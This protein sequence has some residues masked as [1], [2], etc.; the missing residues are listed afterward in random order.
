[1]ADII[2]VVTSDAGPP[3][4]HYQQAVIHAGVV[5]ASG[6]LG[7][8]EMAAGSQRDIQAQAAY[9]LDQLRIVLRAAGSDLDRSLKLTIYV[10]DVAFW[11]TVNQVFAQHFGSHKPA[12]SVVTCA[13]LRLNSLIE[14]DAIAALRPSNSP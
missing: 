1:M 7:A 9:C 14:I 5:Y 6:I 2:P 8:S 11:P 10:T 13:T 3:H 12:R 4:G